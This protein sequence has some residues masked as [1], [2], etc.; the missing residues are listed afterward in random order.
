MRG[1]LEGWPLPNGDI[2][3]LFGKYSIEDIQNA[4]AHTLYRSKF[5]KYQ[6]KHPHKYFLRSLEHKY[7]K[8]YPDCAKVMGLIFVSAVRNEVDDVVPDARRSNVEDTVTI[9][10]IDRRVML[11][12]QTELQAM[13]DG[14]PAEQRHALF[15]KYND[16]LKDDRF[17]LNIGRR[18]RAGSMS[19]FR[20]WYG[21]TVY[22]AISAEE[23]EL[24]KQAILAEAVAT[25]Y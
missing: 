7:F 25:T 20:H 17:K 14:M 19:M 18:N 21:E 24:A 4:Y 11:R 9:E 16:T 13:V 6:L 22:G 23:R 8:D 3:S 15:S 5:E 2:L 1:F 12:R 10:D